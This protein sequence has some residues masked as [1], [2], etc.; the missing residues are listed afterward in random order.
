MRL[1]ASPF[2]RS[3]PRTR[4]QSMVEFALVTPLLL[5][6]FAGAADFGRAFFAYVAIEN[7]AK[8]GAFFGSRLPLCDDASGGACADPNN[9]TWRVR[10]ELRAQGIRNPDGTELTPTVTCLT[11]AGVPR[12]NL[13]DCASGDTY[14][15]GLVYEFRLLTPILGSIIGDLDLGTA[16]RAVVLN[17]AFDP[18]PGTSIQKYVSPVGAVNEAD[19]IAKCL[20]PDDTDAA[21]FYRSPCLD[22]STPDPID[23]VTAKFEQGVTVTYRLVVGNSGVTP[24]TGVTVVDFHWR[25]RLF[26]LRID[27]RRILPDLRLHANRSGRDWSRDDDELRQCRDDR[28]GPDWP[29]DLRR[30]GGRREAAGRVRRREVRQSLPA[31]QRR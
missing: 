26:H 7:A 2:R 11:P 3:R 12:G 17:L 24:L 6:I 23:T 9:V 20:E 4:G 10:T 19:I 1:P 25:H 27:G 14:E 22:S 13:R 30:D 31:R 29:L 18:T 16:S 21:G 8:E 5:L 15:V 28:L